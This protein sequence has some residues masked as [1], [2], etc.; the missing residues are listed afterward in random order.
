MD[1]KTIQEFFFKAMIEGWVSGGKEVSIP[2]FPGFKV[3][4]YERENLR[5]IDMWT[6]IVEGSDKSS[7]VTTIFQNDQPVWIMHYGGSYPKDV[8]F[9]VKTALQN[10]YRN[11]RFCWGRGPESF[12]ISGDDTEYINMGH[13]DFNSFEGR[14]ELFG[15]NRNGKRDLLGYHKYWGMSLTE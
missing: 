7:G 10:A 4:A 8:T 11:K 9:F 13:G 15:K 6:K 5:L 3:I 14:E 12:H 1:M 2:A